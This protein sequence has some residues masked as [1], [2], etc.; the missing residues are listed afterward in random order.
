MSE[1]ILKHSRSNLSIVVST[2]VVIIAMA[3]V[4]MLQLTKILIKP[5]YND[6][7]PAQRSSAKVGSTDNRICLLKLKHSICIGMHNKAKKQ[8]AKNADYFWT[9]NTLNYLY[10][11]LKF[12]IFEI[13]RRHLKFDFSGKWNEK[14]EAHKICIDRI[15]LIYFFNYFFVSWLWRIF[16][17]F[18]FVIFYFSVENNK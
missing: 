7:S 9:L 15:L 4:R 6:N 2:A 12:L 16:N 13:L 17:L 18:Q 14:K 1:P 11:K 5:N 10:I 3:N 8:A